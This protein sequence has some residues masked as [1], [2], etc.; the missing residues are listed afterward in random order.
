MIT[1]KTLNL[2]YLKTFECPTYAHIDNTRRNKFEYN[3]FTNIFDGYAFESPTWLI[4]NPATERVTLSRNAISDEEWKLVATTTPTSILTNTMDDDNIDDEDASS[5]GV[6]QTII[7]SLGEHHPQIP[8]PKDPQLPT[9]RT[10]R[11]ATQLTK[12]LEDARLKMER[13]LRGR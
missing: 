7:S 8:P 12:D 9:D 1:N 10:V 13:E 3:S 6:Q 11:R 4:H 2:S 5:P